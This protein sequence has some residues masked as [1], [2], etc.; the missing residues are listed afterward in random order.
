MNSETH[1][2]NI[3]D[4]LKALAPIPCF[5]CTILT[6]ISAGALITLD[7]QVEWEERSPFQRISALYFPNKR[8]WKV[9]KFQPT[10]IHG[11]TLTK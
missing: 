2:L 7:M 1:M 5:A 11:T 3:P 9:L 8:V 6:A 10:E 4:A